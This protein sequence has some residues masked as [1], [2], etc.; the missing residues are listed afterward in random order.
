MIRVF[1]IQQPRF[2]QLNTNNF[3]SPVQHVFKQSESMNMKLNS[4]LKLVQSFRISIFNFLFSTKYNTISGSTSVTEVMEVLAETYQNSHNNTSIE[5][6]G[7]GSSA[8]VKA[9]KNGTSMFGMSSRELKSS[10]K[11]NL[12]ETV[13]ARDGIAIVVIKS[14]QA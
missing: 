13:I 9:A 7:T 10:E 2:K 14:I 3:T 5:V 8:G 4:F 12:V 6:Q 11:S 1:R